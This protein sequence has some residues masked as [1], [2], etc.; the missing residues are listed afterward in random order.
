VAIPL[1]VGIDGS[2]ASLQTVDSEAHRRP[3]TQVLDGALRGPTERYPYV[4]VS[5]RMIEGPIRQALLE[6]ASGADLLVGGAR[7]RRGHAA[8]QPGL[9]NH[10]VLHHAPC[11]AAGDHDSVE[12]ARRQAWA[13]RSSVRTW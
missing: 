10:A 1:V 5:R 2:E 9:V 12:G 11:P 8:L 13:G 6:A 7:R 3:P 4:S